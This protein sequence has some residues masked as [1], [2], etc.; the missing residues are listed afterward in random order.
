MGK[1]HVTDTGSFTKWGL[2]LHLAAPSV[3]VAFCL[4]RR[5][6]A[7]RQLTQPTDGVIRRRPPAGEWRHPD[8]GR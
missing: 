4:Y 8:E 7:S 2:P 5:R 6:D 3:S 1:Q